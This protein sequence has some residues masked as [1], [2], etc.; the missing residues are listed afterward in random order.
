M[1]IIA[2]FDKNSTRRND[3]NAEIFSNGQLYYPPYPS[4]KPHL[5]KKSLHVHFYDV[6]LSLFVSSSLFAFLKNLFIPIRRS[7]IRLL[8]RILFIFFDAFRRYLYLFFCQ[9]AFTRFLIL[10]YL[11]KI[12]IP[13]FFFLWYNNS[14]L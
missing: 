3:M 9:F 12:A 7:I 8:C 1:E 4:L 13:L 6:P 11:L 10:F 5:V 2:V 14:V